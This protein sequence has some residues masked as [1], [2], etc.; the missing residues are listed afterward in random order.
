[1]GTV[2]RSLGHILSAFA[3]IAGALWGLNA[4]AQERQT[5]LI[6]TGAPGGVYYPL[7]SAMCRMINLD[8]ANSY[9]C[10]AKTSKG[11]VANIEAL[12][13]KKIDF[14]IVQADVE[15]AAA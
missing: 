8:F 6:G 4:G 11:S 15:E 5:L 7:G 12:E 2:M 10:L 3:V 9:R 14:A 13:Q 1:M